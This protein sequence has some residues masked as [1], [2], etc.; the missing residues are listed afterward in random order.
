MLP[1]NPAGTLAF[2][3][4]ICAQPDAGLVAEARPQQPVANPTPDMRQS[5]AQDFVL[6]M[7]YEAARARQRPA[8]A[9]SRR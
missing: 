5:L 1:A 2:W 7:R 9:V 3:R 8:V 4:G 6:S